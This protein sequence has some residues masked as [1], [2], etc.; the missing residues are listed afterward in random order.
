MATNPVVSPV[1]HDVMFAPVDVEPST[2]PTAARVS[3]LTPKYPARYD[4]RT[5]GLVTSVK[6]QGG[7]PSCWVFATYGSLESAV[8]VA[9]GPTLDLS[10]NHMKNCHGFDGGAM[11]GGNYFMSYAYLSRWDGPVSEEDDPYNDYD[12]RPSRGG[13]PQLYVRTMLMLDT[14][15]EIKGCLVTRGAVGTS[16]YSSQTYHDEETHTYYY[17]GT[18]RSNHAVT[19]IGWDDSLVVPGA[20]APGAWLIKNSHGPESGD[21]GYFWL[22]YADAAGANDGFCFC[23]AVGPNTYQKAYYHDYFGNMGSLAHEYAF[24]AFTA[25]SDQEL[26]AVQFWTK[27]DGAGYDVR[28]YDEFSFGRLSGLLGSVAGTQPLAGAHTVDLPS[29]TPLAQGNDFYIYVHL[30]DGGEYPLAADWAIKGHNSPRKTGPGLSYFSLDGISWT[31]LTT[32]EPTASFCIRG[33]VATDTPPLITVEGEGVPIDDGEMASSAESGTFFGSVTQSSPP[34]ERTFAVRNDGSGTLVLDGVTVPAG[35][36]LADVPAATLAPG[37]SDTFAVSLDT[38]EVGTMSG[39]IAVLNDDRDRQPFNFAVSGIVTGPKIVTRGNG[40]L[41]ANGAQTSSQTDGTDFGAV[42]W[43]GSPTRRTFQ[44]SNEGNAALTLGP[45]V[46]PTG[47][48][49]AKDL[50]AT[51]AA[52]A[53]D[54][55]A[56][57]LDTA[58]VGTKTGDVS[59]LNDDAQANPF[60]FVITGVVT[61]E[62]EVTVLGNGV[63]IASGSA[64]PNPD[65][66]TH[67]GSAVLGGAPI[68]RTFTVRNDGALPL[69]LGPVLVPEGFTLAEGLSSNLSSGQADTF[70]ISLETTTA[71]IKTG[72]VS[73]ATSDSDESPFYFRITGRV[74][75]DEE[76]VVFADPALEAAVQDALGAW[77]PTPTDMLALTDL[78]AWGVGIQNLQGLEC[79]TNL[80][81]LGLWGNPITDLS[82]LAGLTKL[83]E[84]HLGRNLCSDI[85]PLAGLTDLTTLWLDASGISDISALAGLTN[86]TFL[87]LW[88]NE[89]K[90]I[91]PLAGLTKLTFL[92]LWSNQVKDITPLAGLTNLA[93]LE[94]G[95]CQEIDDISTLA[96]LTDLALL[97]LC[98]NQV[99]DITSLAGLTRL[100]HL[101]LGGNHISDIAALA[102]LTTLTHLELG[103]NQIGDL[104][105]LAGLTNLAHLELGGNPISDVSALAGLTRLTYLEFG[106]NQI[107]D[108]SAFAGMTSL[109]ELTIHTNQVDS[110]GVVVL[111]GLTG[112]TKL[113]LTANAIEDIAPLAELTDLTELAIGGNPIGD[114]SALS[115]LTNLTYLMIN[116]TRCNDL[117]VLSG[118]ANLNVL[119]AERNSI[120]DISILP[121]LTNLT[122]IFLKAN[123]IRDISPLLGFTTLTDLDLR[124]NPLNAD[125]YETYIPLILTNNRTIRF[126]YDP[127]KLDAVSF[128]DPALK[129]AIEEALDVR[130][131]GPT[132]M[133]MLTQLTAYRKGIQNLEGL[134]YA[135]NLT[136]LLLRDNQISDIS[137]LA[138]LTKLRKLDLGNNRVSEITA[139]ASMTDLTDLRLY[140][141]RITDITALTGLTRLTYL[142]ALGNQISNISALA[143][144][145][146]LTE[147][148]LRDNQIS[149]ITPLAGLTHLTKLDVADNQIGNVSVLVGL[150]KLTYLDA[151][152]N[153]ISNISALA[154][155][156][157]LTEL[158][159]TRNKISDIAALAGLTELTKLNLENNQISSISVLS[160]LTRLRELSVA[161]NRIGSRSLSALSGLTSLTTLNLKENLIDDISSLAGLTNLTQLTMGGNSIRDVSVLSGLT[162]LNR[163]EA[164]NNAIQDITVLAG[165]TNLPRVL[166]K[167]NDIS[168]LSPLAYVTHLIELDLRANPLNAEAYAEYIPLIRAHND[169][170]NFKYDPAPSGP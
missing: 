108:I 104:S 67:F 141:N 44:V 62:A 31:D 150:T 144:L 70:T 45:V 166:L 54:T 134:Q 114:F 135:V 93:H 65:D 95:Y 123:C 7:A 139:L 23:D 90:D 116:G 107:S 49:L 91:R 2:A 162:Q 153:Q 86:L 138:D 158:Y 10:E 164:P 154:G 63:W 155:L 61:D 75:A 115:G 147:L 69:A 50:A 119:K 9:G 21:G 13:P 81:S 76:P 82:P 137:A 33:L 148:H 14:D 169:G 80:T 6:N 57:Q 40:G 84:L 157:Q 125:A 111:S 140:R 27:A 74:T 129:V 1:T 165:L 43:G 16:M 17:D 113:D 149:D 56:I 97:N 160:G 122:R 39:H 28:I 48:T 51:L 151:L 41:I 121:G 4:L 72:D 60:H 68:S 132:D 145:A 22:S 8:L 25:T 159:L 26:A 87:D 89:V 110:P 24:N 128:G 105:A 117:S 126:D 130:N 3:M 167:G 34:I 52:G 136:E 131:P 73:F 143:G 11:R 88:A 77:R 163:L 32:V 124:A 46:V 35:F 30:T 64:T 118:L 100:A 101:K 120:S 133:L 94:L 102:N 47:F 156:T 99:E 37:A 36:L 19:I 92:S 78:Q 59:F 96:G 15:E 38:A 152:G 127:L 142:D 29:P 5:D 106:N 170:I 85:T 12:D 53:S 98:S 66:H 112:L 161:Q 168:D 83:T 109:K 146:Q 55:F 20:P 58:A 71:G 103:S 42:A 18:A 79:A